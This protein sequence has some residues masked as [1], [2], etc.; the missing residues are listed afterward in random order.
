MK[1]LGMV[2]IL[3]SLVACGRKNSKIHTADLVSTEGIK[4]SWKSDCLGSGLVFEFIITETSLRLKQNVFSSSECLPGSESTFYAFDQTYIHN[5]S[6]SKI[7]AIITNLYVTYWNINTI[8]SLNDDQPCGPKDWQI[9][10]EK[11]ITNISPCAFFGSTTGGMS[12]AYQITFLDKDT[13][14]WIDNDFNLYRQ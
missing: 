10:V 5:E 2:L 8:N 3:L 12:K 9:G 6:Q 7:D 14:F 11:E 1:V 13:L 4:G